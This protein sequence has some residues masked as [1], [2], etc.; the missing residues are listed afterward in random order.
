MACDKDRSMCRGCYNEDYWHG[1]GGAKECW[2]Y[3]SAEV[4]PRIEIPVDMRPPYLSL[5]PR[6]VLSC[7]TKKRYVQVKPESL[8][9]DGY[10]RS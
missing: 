6:Q 4:V 7:Y 5:E 9:E 3:E 2:S 8:T 1:L 10:W